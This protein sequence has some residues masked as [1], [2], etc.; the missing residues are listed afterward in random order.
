M[1]YMGGKFSA[2]GPAF[3]PLVG[4]WISPDRWSL[5]MFRYSWPFI[6]AGVILLIL[7]GAIFPVAGW[8]YTLIGMT[9]Y[10]AWYWIASR[11]QVNPRH[12]QWV[13]FMR[14]LAPILFAFT[15]IIIFGKQVETIWLLFFIPMLTV[16]LEV[17]RLQA[18]LVIAVDF[19]AV[20]TGSII[21]ANAPLSI[22]SEW[23][24]T[25]FQSSLLKAVI[26]SYVGITSYFLSRSLAFIHQVNKRLLDLLPRIAPEP[27]GWQEA[28]REV[29]L[30]VAESFSDPHNQMVVNILTL[31][32][33]Q[34][35]LTA[36]SLDSGQLLVKDKFSFSQQ[37]GITGFTA[38]TGCTIFINDVKN[39]PNHLYYPHPAFPGIQAELCVPIKVADKV[40][41]VIDIEARRK[42]AFGD[43]DRQA[44]EI[45][46][47]HLAEIYKQTHLLGKYQKIADL[48]NK[49]A[50]NIIGI[51]DLGQLL[52]EIGDV[53]SDVLDSQLI[54]YYFRDP[55]NGSTKGPYTSGSVKFPDLSHPKVNANRLV[56]KLFLEEEIKVF[57]DAQRS[58][59][60]T[61]Q[62]DREHGHLPFV[63]REEII[64]CAVVPL[65]VRAESI[66]LMFI[67]YRRKE[68]F[69]QE[70]RDMIE[71]IAPLAALAIQ[72]AIQEEAAVL[73]KR[74][75]V[76]DEL[77]DTVSHR[78]LAAK[79][80]LEKLEQW[81]PASQDWKDHLVAAA[82]YIQSANRM[83]YDLTHHHDVDQLRS[84]N[85]PTLLEEVKT[86]AGLIK[87]VFGVN[88]SVDH[89][90]QL[91]V[92][93]EAC[94][95]NAEVQHIVDEALYNAARH[96]HADSIRVNFST[97]NSLLAIQI[98]DD[99]VGF[100]PGIVKVGTGLYQLRSKVQQ[101]LKGSM[102]LKTAPGKGTCLTFHIPLQ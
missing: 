52:K 99:G 18:V 31:Y 20:M 44:M 62:S 87:R 71:I 101:S 5:S 82:K 88:V 98:C 39:D 78:I 58:Q 36:S 97:V 91:L 22:T 30:K 51:R 37:L 95:I 40:V 70:L 9:A 92:E 19:L 80:S 84:T 86:D 85:I 16:G 48:S 33:D 4:S 55:Q 6:R 46:A 67:N 25:T 100:D 32:G 24:L 75:K 45:I 15:L 43:E 35:C 63:I 27:Y 65:R 76:L 11:I 73:V 8:V 49:L 96:A 12:T 79:I 14:H 56:E 1:S 13:N 3:K 81:S 57:E 74:Q 93:F 61:E 94:P 66:G 60:L 10:I 2:Y 102:A 54:G 34:I 42:N 26:V 21:I 29:V 7:A 68:E 41:A 72:S 23:I 17:S 53:S 28:V 59:E 69:S 77:H 64:S 89:A 50:A 38:K 83:I 90:P 47:A